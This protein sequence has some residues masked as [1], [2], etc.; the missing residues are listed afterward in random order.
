[1]IRSRSAKA[2]GPFALPDSTRWPYPGLT[3]ADSHQA[4]KDVP[5]RIKSALTVAVW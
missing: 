3:P 4:R 2:A 5:C 1:M